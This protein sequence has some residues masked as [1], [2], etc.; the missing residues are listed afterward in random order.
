M[1]E[2]E[3]KHSRKVCAGRARDVV[4]L[5]LIVLDLGTRE[6]RDDWTSRGKGH[7]LAVSAAPH[8]KRPAVRFV[9]RVVDEHD[10]V[11]LV[12]RDRS[13]RGVH[14]VDGHREEAGGSHIRR[15]RCA[16][17]CR[18]TPEAGGA[19][20]PTREIGSASRS[21]RLGEGGAC[22]STHQLGEALRVTLPACTEIGAAPE[23]GVTV[24][25]TLLSMSTELK[26]EPSRMRRH[27]ST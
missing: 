4:Q 12:G 24:T 22:D 26:S 6:Q 21:Q 1:P 13:R 23:V 7:A 20:I 3:P 11:E 10:C 16:L 17:P 27:E 9:G 25:V 14:R 8:L 15:R 19:L 2:T 18:G 5:A